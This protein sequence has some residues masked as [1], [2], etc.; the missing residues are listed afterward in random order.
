[1]QVSSHPLPSVHTPSPTP[2]HTF[3]HTQVPACLPHWLS[4][5]CKVTPRSLPSGTL[6]S[7]HC[8]YTLLHTNSTQ[9]APV[10]FHCHPETFPSQ[11]FPFTLFLLSGS[12]R[13]SPSGPSAY[14]YCLLPFCPRLSCPQSHTYIHIKVRTFSHTSCGCSP[15]IQH[16]LSSIPSLSSHSPSYH[17]LVALPHTH[18]S[19]KWQP[20]QYSCLENPM[21]R[22]ARRATAHR[23]AEADM[24]EHLTQSLLSSALLLSRIPSLSV[25]LSLSHTHSHTDQ[26]SPRYWAFQLPQSHTQLGVVLG[27]GWLPGLRP[28]AEQGF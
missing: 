13:A 23:V 6:S 24:T 25:S 2:P 17:K 18:L 8:L 16:T 9:K 7:S 1:M 26:F 12:P 14:A 21:D 19:R 4:T 27:R 5:L 22:G 20:L 15:H 3:F 28:R 10:Y 11:P